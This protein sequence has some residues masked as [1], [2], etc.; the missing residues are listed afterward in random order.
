MAEGSPTAEAAGARAVNVGPGGLIDTKA[1]GKLRSFDGKEDS[2]ATWSFVARSY[3]TLLSPDFDALLDAVEAQPLGGMRLA[4]PASNGLVHAKTLYHILA[5]SVEGKALSILM[6][7][8]KQNGFEGWKALVEA[9]QPDL[10]GRHTSMLMGIISPAWEKSTEATFLEHLEN[11]EVLIRRYQDQATDV[12]T[13]ATKIAILMKYAPASLRN[14]LRTNATNMGTDYD[15]V[16]KF[17]SG[18][19]AERG[20]LPAV[21]V[22]SSRPARPA[23]KGRPPWT[24]APSATTTRARPKERTAKARRARRATRAASRVSQPGKSSAATFQGECGFCGKWGHKRKDCWAKQ[25]KDK[26]NGK[27]QGGGKTTAVESSP[28]SPTGT[29]AAVYYDISGGEA[30]HEAEDEED[31]EIRWV[32]AINAGSLEEP[33]QNQ[34]ENVRAVPAE[35]ASQPSS[36]T[37]RFR[38]AAP[39]EQG[40]D[41]D[42]WEQAGQEHGDEAAEEDVIQIGGDVNFGRRGKSK[43]TPFDKVEK[44][45][46]RLKELGKPRYGTKA[47]LWS[48]LEK[49]E[50]EH[51]KTQRQHQERQR[52]LR[53]GVAEP[54]EAP[55]GP[56]EP[57]PE[58]RAQ[59]ELAQAPSSR[60]VVR[61]LHQGACH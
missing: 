38:T 26:G 30:E 8:E 15:K 16:K 10:G 50:K 32:M 43:L 14:A 6:N 58:Q 12:V 4:R 25:A 29:A 45:K 56:Q 17:I 37:T 61:A 2:W 21:P 41:P 48:R 53:E 18:L 44:L 51:M 5:Q 59:H 13:S 52:K 31:D 19:A 39:V 1:Y 7:V 23:T 42:E 49:A 11:W 57:T 46:A 22:R 33:D 36:P 55:P 47:E 3:F 34:D 60:A 27:G 35:G 28:T 40:G 54:V 9:Y 20:D 24:W